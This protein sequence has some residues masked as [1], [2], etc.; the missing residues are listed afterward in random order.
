MS[1]DLCHVIKVLVWVRLPLL[2]RELWSTEMLSRIRSILGTPMFTDHCTL[3][4][5]KLGFARM[6]VE[7]KV[8]GEFPTMVVL[9]DDNGVQLHQ[10][11][12]YEWRHIHCT[13]CKGDGHTSL[14]CLNNAR[15]KP[16]KVW[17]P[18]VPKETSNPEQQQA[19]LEPREMPM[20]SQP[21]G[22]ATLANPED[23]ASKA[24]CQTVKGV[25]NGSI[26]K[27]VHAVLE[28]VVGQP[29]TLITEGKRVG[30]PPA[31]LLC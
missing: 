4:K 16:L 20:S 14:V 10:K 26:L 22:V 28:S 9:E 6:L 17:R 2:P 3:N 18:K 12:L 13:T 31:R 11:V 30:R 27:G 23:V 19:L 25:S 1:F 8:L 21:G 24:S 5:E 29:S 7:M 15:K